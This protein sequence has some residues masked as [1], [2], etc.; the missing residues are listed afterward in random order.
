VPVGDILVGD[1]GRDIE[2]DDAAL[3]I[4]VVSI[5][6]TSELLL[7]GGIPDIEL[8]GAEVL[9]QKISALS[10]TCLESWGMSSLTVVKPRG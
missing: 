8:D 10:F 7:T 4:N 2:H 1:A 5:T 9:M 3:A 6:E